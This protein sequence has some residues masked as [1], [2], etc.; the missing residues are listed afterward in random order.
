MSQSNFHDKQ[1]LDPQDLF[2]QF[3]PKLFFNNPILANSNWHILAEQSVPVKVDS[4]WQTI[5]RWTAEPELVIPPI[6]KA[7]IISIT[8]TEGKKV[9]LRELVPKRKSKDANLREEISYIDTDQEARVEYRHL[10][11]M[12]LLPFFYPKVY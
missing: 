2:S 3:A 12:S 4:F 8:E 10:T 1:D 5:E 9:V 11:E 7:E 6:E